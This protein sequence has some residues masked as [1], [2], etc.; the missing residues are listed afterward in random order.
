MGPG[1]AILLYGPFSLFSGPC[2][3][4]VATWVHCHSNAAQTTPETTTDRSSYGRQPQLASTN[5][6]LYHSSGELV[7]LFMEH[8]AVVSVYCME[9]SLSHDSIHSPLLRESIRWT[10]V[11]TYTHAS[12]ESILLHDP[13][14]QLRCSALVVQFVCRNMDRY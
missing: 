6:S 13:V 10:A 4:Q 12:I 7:Q 3:K 1:L 8:R 5:S 11:S 2:P 14:H 9:H